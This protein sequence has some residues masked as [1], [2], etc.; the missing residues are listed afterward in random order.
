M[1]NPRGLASVYWTTLHLLDAGVTV[2]MSEALQHL[3]AG[4]VLE[5]LSQLSGEWER[6]TGL[7]ALIRDDPHSAQPVRDVFNSHRGIE[8]AALGEIE[9]N[10][11]CLILG[12]CLNQL[13]IET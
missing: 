9:N 3:D 7:L 10:G 13:Q 2:P 1:A 8:V 11:L 12:I 6:Q 4:D 5:W